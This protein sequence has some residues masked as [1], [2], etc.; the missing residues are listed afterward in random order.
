MGEGLLNDFLDGSVGME[1]AE[2]VLDDGGGVV[3]ALLHVGEVFGVSGE[4]NL[5]EFYASVGELLL[6]VLAVPTIRQGVDVN[7]A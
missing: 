3:A 1:V 2:L 4:V 6:G 7:H 5:G